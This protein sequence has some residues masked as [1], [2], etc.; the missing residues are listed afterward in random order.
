M[1]RLSDQFTIAL[2]LT[3]RACRE[4]DLPDLEWFGLLTEYRQI[5][6]NAFQRFQKGEIM[7]LVAEANH[8][9]VGQVWID[10]TKRR[11]DAIGVLW[12]LRVLLPFQNNGR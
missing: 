8:F 12:A 3:I 6:T 1:H 10:L 2:Q 5:I 9:P 4:T 7:M 11:Q